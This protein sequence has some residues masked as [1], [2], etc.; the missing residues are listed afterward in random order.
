MDA[1]Q[2]NYTVAYEIIEI[3]SKRGCTV[4]QSEGILSFVGTTIRETATV[5]PS[6]ELGRLGDRTI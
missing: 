2:E 4:R 5:Q 1:T 6:E 3:L